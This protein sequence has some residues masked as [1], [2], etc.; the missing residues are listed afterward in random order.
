MI[1]FELC[2]F[3]F[4]FINMFIYCLTSSFTLFELYAKNPKLYNLVSY[5]IAAKKHF[6]VPMVSSGDV[7][8]SDKKKNLLPSLWDLKKCLAT[9]W[10]CILWR[11]LLFSS[12]YAFVQVSYDKMRIFWNISIFNPGQH[13]S[14]QS[15]QAFFLPKMDAR[16]L[17]VKS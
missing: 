2:I 10:G 14:L 15:E 9:S 1:N 3:L 8:K 16:A 17:A 5:G 7:T 11:L 12:W 6:L 13:S 4:S